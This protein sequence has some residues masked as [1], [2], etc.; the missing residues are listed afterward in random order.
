MKE[1][2]IEDN[3]INNAKDINIINP[4]NENTYSNLKIKENDHKNSIENINGDE[5][6]NKEF[7]PDEQSATLMTQIQF[8]D[9]K[10]NQGALFELN[11]SLEKTDDT[12]KNSSNIKEDQK[13]QN[14]QKETFFQKT[15]RWAGTAWSYINIANYFPKEEFKEYRNANGDWVKIPVK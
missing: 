2:N 1:S 3:I 14:Q 15:K 7:K 8:L 11:K 4:L 12:S 6:K 5:I 10:R 13:E 9:N